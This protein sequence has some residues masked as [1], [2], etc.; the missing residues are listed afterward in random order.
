M[1]GAGPG[2]FDQPVDPVADLLEVAALHRVGVV[3]RRTRAGCSSSLADLLARALV[4]G[5]RVRQGVGAHLVAAHLPQDPP[6][7]VARRGVH[8]H[9]AHQV[10]VDRVGRKAAR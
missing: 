6:A 9:V 3:A 10:D 2:P 5:V 1:A 8:D 7:G 4:V